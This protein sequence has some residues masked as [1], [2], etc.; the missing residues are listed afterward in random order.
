MRSS[1]QAYKPSIRCVKSKLGEVAASE[2]KS[3]RRMVGAVVGNIVLVFVLIIM[4]DKRGMSCIYVISVC[5]KWISG[6]VIHASFSE[7]VDV[8]LLEYKTVVYTEV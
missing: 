2:V 7:F 1:G 4:L 3:R 6:Y 8:D 5:C